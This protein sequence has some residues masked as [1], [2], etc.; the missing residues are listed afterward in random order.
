MR[1]T[2]VAALALLPVTGACSDD[3]TGGPSAGNADGGVAPAGDGLAQGEGGGPWVGAVTGA[4][5]PVWALAA[6]A[7]VAF[8]VERAGEDAP[9]R[10]MRAVPGGGPAVVV[11]E[12]EPADP[13]W[14]TSSPMALDGD[15]LVFAWPGDPTLR[16]VG[17]TG[18]EVTTLATP[19]QVS[20]LALGPG[21]A[22]WTA[23]DEGRVWRVPR[24]GGP[25][26]ELATLEFPT[27]AV[28]GPDG[29]FVVV[30]LAAWMAHFT[31]D[32]AAVSSEPALFV[33]WPGDNTMNLAGG[34]THLVWSDNSNGRLMAV[35]R[36]GGEKHV[37]AEGAAT[38]DGAVAVGAD[39]V[40]V[41]PGQ[42]DL[43]RTVVRWPLAGGEKT[44]IGHPGE[45]C[46]ARVALVGTTVLWSRCDGS[47]EATPLP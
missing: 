11:A 3:T 28:A 24:A 47:I 40:I 9:S 27:G 10:L 5:G 17:V 31:P 43:D 29:L 44:A 14:S 20:G 6:D 23:H 8:W 33:T 15:D 7:R 12:A 37:V 4:G 13:M 41:A 35:P 46:G 19:E 34:P 32:G 42:W 21:W 18:G 39:D 38:L 16:R 30:R 22:Y 25:A 2:L 36:A 26:E 45:G 1:A